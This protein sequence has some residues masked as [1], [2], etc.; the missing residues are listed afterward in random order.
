MEKPM[1]KWTIWGEKPAR[2]RSPRPLPIRQ[3]ET[4]VWLDRLRI[5]EETNGGGVAWKSTQNW[6]SRK[7][8][9]YKPWVL[10]LGSNFC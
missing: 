8:N 5:G 4:R 10:L 1:N 2:C 9:I 7:E 6:D 3:V